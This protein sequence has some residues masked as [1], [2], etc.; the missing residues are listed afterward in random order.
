MKVLSCSVA[1]VLPLLVA[2]TAMAED[3]THDGFFFQLTGGL[4]YYS[5]T[6]D[7]LLGVEPKFSGTTT[8]TSLMLGGSIIDGLAV[9][10]GMFYD[11]AT[12]P[13][14]T[15]DGDELDSGITSQYVIGLGAF[16]NLY[17]P[18][19]MVDG[20][21]VQGF[22]GWGGLESSFEG[23]VGG[24]DPTGTVIAFGAGKDWFLT[25]EL[26]FGVMARLMRGSFELNGYGYGT[27]APA[28]VATL[29]YN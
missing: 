29:T 15:V 4:G 9:G 22:Y 13:K 25:D 11:K 28:L 21:F 26:S 5:A 23:N 3:E 7:E 16:A 18:I 1:L 24:S 10:F 14:Y 2:T 8:A 27:T 20:V 19:P 6:G 17:L 12:S